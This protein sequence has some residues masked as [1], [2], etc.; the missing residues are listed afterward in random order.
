MRYA[1]TIL[2]ILVGFNVFAQKAGMKGLETAI[3]AFDKALL[4]RDSTEL[5]HLL[6][7]KLSY[8][9][10]NGWLQTRQNVIEDLY[11]GKIIYKQITPTTPE[12]VVDGNIASAR[13]IAD[14]DVVMDGKQLQF[15]LKVLQVW[16][17]KNDHWEMFARQSVKMN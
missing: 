13:M 5:K 16:N 15:K 7:D 6:S 14:V 2:L 10:S 9:H 1:V 17:R 11:N 12:I 4:N 3:A 8:G